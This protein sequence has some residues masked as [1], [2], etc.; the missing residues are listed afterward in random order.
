VCDQL[1]AAIFVGALTPFSPSAC[2]LY[3]IVASPFM[4]WPVYR[5]CVVSLAGERLPKYGPF[6]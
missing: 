5:T 4:V 3:D 6:G 1:F 2:M